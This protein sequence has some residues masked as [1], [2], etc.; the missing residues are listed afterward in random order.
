M[1]VSGCGKSTIGKALSEHWNA[2]FFDGDDFHPAANIAKMAGGNPL[3]DSD[4]APWLAAINAFAKDQLKT[5]GCIIA[6]SALKK[7]YRDIL[8]EGQADQT[9]FIHLQGSFD[10]IQARMAARDHFMPPALLQS[11]FDTLEPPDNAIDIDINLSVEQIIAA[12]DIKTNNHMHSEIGLVGLGVMGTSLA[13]NIASKG[14]QISLF[15]RRVE[16]KEE[17]VAER[18]IEQFDELKNAR[19]FEDLK[20]FIQSIERPRKIIL[21]I[22]AGAVDYFIDYVQ[23]LLDDGDI[24][25]DGGNTFYKDTIRRKAALDTKGINWI[26]AGVSGG[27]EGALRGPSIMV[28]GTPAA[29][30]K[31]LPILQSIAAKDSKG[32]PCCTL[33]G[34]GASG[35]FVKMVHNGIEYAEMQLIA[36]AYDLLRHGNGWTTDRVADCFE[37]WNSGDL[38]SYLLEISIDILRKNQGGSLVLD[39][40]LDVASN[41]GTGS[42]TTSTAASLGVA[43]PTLTA[44]LNARFIS[45]DKLSRATLSQSM[46]LLDNESIDSV[47]LKSGYALCRILNH[48]QGFRL[49]QAASDE[50][51]WKI[52]ITSL[53]TIWTNG[54]IIRSKLMESIA[55]IP[56]D[57]KL[58]GSMASEINKLQ[59]ALG[60]V[61]SAAAK[62]KVA[63]PCFMASLTYLQGMTRAQSSANM[64]QAQRDYFGAH[65]PTGKSNLCLTE[66]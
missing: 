43:V 49:I 42:W 63:M 3:N 60:E 37:D 2:P 15:N 40:I 55:Q 57:Q 46:Q 53:A 18:A 36:E 5:N 48:I 21:M 8:S 41:K 58:F 11:Q 35:H 25:I 64:I 33:V 56:S 16:G 32:D 39:Q 61:V 19:G 24:L 50:Y 47:V 51:N 28:G 52:N 22:T 7:S 14:Y 66:Y 6:C 17:R 65:I 12:I 62:G 59:S 13:R 23:N 44:A 9:T 20:A 29:G 10:L 26:G 31:V 34:D 1:G 30:E 54:C 27:E 4:R 45:S 38:N